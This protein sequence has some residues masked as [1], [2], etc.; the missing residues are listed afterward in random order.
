MGVIAT[1]LAELGIVLATPPSPSANYV[2]VRR[3]G[4]MAFVSGQVPSVNGVDRFQGQLGGGVSLAD[5]Q[6]AARLCAINLLTQLNAFFAGDLDRVVSVVRLGGFVNAAPG[7]GD[8]PK[9]VNGASDFMVE[10]FG[11]AGRHVRVA[12]GSSSL[13]RDVSVEIEGMFEVQ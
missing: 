13:P 7:F 6:A 4:T 5:G 12:V 10:V 2:P 11:E 1:R 3:V 8:H 9:V